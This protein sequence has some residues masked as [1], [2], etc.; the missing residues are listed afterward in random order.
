MPFT[1]ELLAGIEYRLMFSAC[2][3]HVATT[4]AFP[5]GDTEHCQVIGFG[6]AGGEHQILG[7]RANER[8]H[9]S[10]RL[11]NRCARRAS[12]GVRR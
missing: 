5:A 3:D 9:L 6:G 10:S 11:L 8:R 2:S 7:R 1:L 4:S 12:K